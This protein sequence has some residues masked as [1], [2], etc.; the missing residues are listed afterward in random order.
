MLFAPFISAI[1]FSAFL[2]LMISAFSMSAT[3]LI[4]RYPA[5]LIFS[6]ATTIRW[7]FSPHSYN[8]DTSPSLAAKIHFNASRVPF[9]PPTRCSALRKSARSNKRYPLSSALATILSIVVFCAT[10]WLKS[11]YA[12][13]YVSLLNSTGRLI[14]ATL[15][16]SFM[17][18]LSNTS[19]ITLACPIWRL[20]NSLTLEL[21]NVL[22]YLA[23]S[24]S[25]A[26]PS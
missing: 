4:L 12:L 23:L 26:A 5:G 16:L 24:A 6:R 13:L 15:Y 10:N 20:L 25:N 17:A 3:K 21:I 8:G 2:S 7:S 14:T 11:L 9:T 18:F 22:M 1:S 19:R